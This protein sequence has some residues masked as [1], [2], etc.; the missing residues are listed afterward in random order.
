MTGRGKGSVQVK[1]MPPHK[2]GP[3][4]GNIMHK[5]S[6]TIHMKI[7]TVF[8]IITEPNP[9]LNQKPFLEV[10]GYIFSQID[11]IPHRCITPFL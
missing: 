3:L 8:L 11:K 4:F 2:E 6:N 1:S 9:Y 5:S 10:Q 7:I